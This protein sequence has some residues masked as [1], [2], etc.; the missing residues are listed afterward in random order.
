MAVLRAKDGYPVANELKIYD[1]S[2]SDA[3]DESV[4]NLKFK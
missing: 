3:L 4:A 2:K 1:E